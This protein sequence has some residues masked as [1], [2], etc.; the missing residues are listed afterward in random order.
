MLGKIFRK[1][2][3]EESLLHFQRFLRF[4]TT[5]LDLGRFVMF[6]RWSYLIG[7]DFEL[8]YSVTF[9]VTKS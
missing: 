4:S 3:Q 1:G 2:I 5:K 7:L 9:V 8:N 6:S